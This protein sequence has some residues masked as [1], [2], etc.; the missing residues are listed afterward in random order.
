MI[1]KVMCIGGQKNRILDTRKLEFQNKPDYCLL[2]SQDSQTHPLPLPK[3]I[4]KMF[5]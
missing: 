5:I 3:Q 2:M 4:L 1:L